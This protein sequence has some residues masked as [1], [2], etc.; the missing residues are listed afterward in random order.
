[1][2]GT[3]GSG[4]RWAEGWGNLLAADMGRSFTRKSHLT[5]LIKQPED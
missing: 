2:E 5:S 4:G 3:V 1:M